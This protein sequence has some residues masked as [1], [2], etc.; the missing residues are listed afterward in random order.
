MRVYWTRIGIALSVLFNVITGGY[1][2][3]TFSARNYAWKKDGRWNVVWL[4]DHVFFWDENHCMHSWVYW[5]SRKDVIHEHYTWRKPIN[6]DT[7]KIYY[8]TQE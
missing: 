1:S 7:D 5:R 4:I 6:V 2:N 3:Q 8:W